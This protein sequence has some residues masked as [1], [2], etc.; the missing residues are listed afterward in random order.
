M[1]VQ[2]WWSRGVEAWAGLFEKEDSDGGICMI[3][4]VR[5]RVSVA[6]WPRVR[7]GMFPQKRPVPTTISGFCIHK[8]NEVDAHAALY[9][10][11]RS[12]QDQVDPLH[13]VAD[14]AVEDYRTGHA[15]GC[16][17][18]MCFHSAQSALTSRRTRYLEGQV[19]LHSPKT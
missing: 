3:R 2:G 15:F 17:D 19:W 1:G 7:L 11:L 9:H 10:C 13:Y 4:P 18:L 8:A 12:Y 16:K 6:L 5:K 14:R